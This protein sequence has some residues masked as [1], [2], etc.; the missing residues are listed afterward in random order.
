MIRWE[1]VVSEAP[2]CRRDSMG[3]VVHEGKMWIFGGYTPTRIND[4]WAGGGA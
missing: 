1:K 3:E 4:V 2:W